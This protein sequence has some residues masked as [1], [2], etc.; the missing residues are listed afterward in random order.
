MEQDS[1]DLSVGDFF[2]NKNNEELSE[3][4]LDAVTKDQVDLDLSQANLEE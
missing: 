4:E 1:L 2:P 3:E